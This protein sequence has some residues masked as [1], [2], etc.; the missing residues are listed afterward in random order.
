LVLFLDVLAAQTLGPLYE[1]VALSS[2]AVAVLLFALM[3]RQTTLE[4]RP[5]VDS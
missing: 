4:V 3:A 2:A 1:A 5:F